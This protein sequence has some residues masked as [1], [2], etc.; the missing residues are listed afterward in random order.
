MYIAMNRFNVLPDQTK[1][2]E[3]VWR[4]RDSQL[5]QVP[6]F[7]SFALLKGAK[8]DDHVLYASHT[9]WRDEAAFLAWTK[10][11]HFRKAHAS[12]GSADRPVT[13]KGHPN[14]EGFVAVL[15]A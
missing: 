13:T 3:D 12:A 14:F 9:I 1:V 11:D 6:G 5:D 2:F 15:E 8:A 4:N 10:S 7:V